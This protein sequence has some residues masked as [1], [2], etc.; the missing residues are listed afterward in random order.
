M[1]SSS[2]KNLTAYWIFTVLTAVL[3]AVPGLA[4]LLRVPHFTEDIAI[5]GYPTYFTTILGV[6]KLLWCSCHL[7]PW[8]VSLEGMG[9]RWDG[10]RS[11]KCCDPEP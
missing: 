1:Y 10:I 4:L 3:F 8:F 5:L 9:L 6:S 11:N 7:I 2:A